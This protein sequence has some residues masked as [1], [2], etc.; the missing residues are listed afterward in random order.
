MKIAILGATG[1]I[2]S[3][4]AGEA[5]TRGHQV[6]AVVRDAGKLV[7]RRLSAAIGDATNADSLARAVKGH[8]AVVSAIGPARGASPSV[9][10]EA[11]RALIDALGRAGVKRV[12]IVGGAGSLEV[13]PGLQLVDTPTFPAQWKPGALAHRD[14][15]QMWRKNTALDWTYLSP[16]ALIAPGPRTGRYRT[17]GDQLLVDAKGESRISAEDF[18]AAL[19]DELEK[20]R[21]LRRRMTVA[22]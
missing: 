12:L 9:L 18:A 20:P 10:G 19:V 2:G 7:D 15:L 4:I 11:T 13:K 21:N 8:D 5:L 14:V 22:Y 17:G 16:A 6:T 1:T 3:R